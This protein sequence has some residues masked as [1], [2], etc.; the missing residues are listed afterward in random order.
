MENVK[1]WKH[2]CAVLNFQYTHEKHSVKH[3]TLTIKFSITPI[4]TKITTWYMNNHYKLLRNIKFF[5]VEEKSNNT[6]CKPIM[7]GTFSNWIS[8]TLIF[9]Y[10]FLNLL[11]RS[12]LTYTVFSPLL[13][14][15]VLDTFFCITWGSSCLRLKNYCTVCV[16]V[17]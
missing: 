13:L 3:Y 2:A 7:N 17:N 4:T 16:Q 12:S 14:S 9:F 10:V 5:K 11:T 6:I 1:G 15:L 8:S